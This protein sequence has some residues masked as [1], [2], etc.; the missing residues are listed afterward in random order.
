VS[1]AIALR[2]YR[3]RLGFAKY[4]LAMSAENQVFVVRAGWRF[5]GRRRRLPMITIIEEGWMP[6]PGQLWG[7]KLTSRSTS[8][9]MR[10]SVPHSRVGARVKGLDETPTLKRIGR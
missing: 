2:V 10:C 6:R 7:V 5:V 9:S 8:R 1:A 4:D 3:H